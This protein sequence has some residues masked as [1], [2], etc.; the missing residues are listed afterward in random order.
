MEIE[1]KFLISDNDIINKII[2]EYSKKKIVQDYLYIDSYTAI[3]KRKIIIKSTEKY[4]YTVKTMKVG[5]SVNE[6]EKEITKDEY[7]SLKLNKGYNTLI[8]DRYLIHI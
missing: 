8:K 6:F 4:M 5:L 1:R 3:R 2:K 7:N